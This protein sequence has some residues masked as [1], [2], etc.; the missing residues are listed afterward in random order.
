MKLA[1]QSPQRESF[2][3][4]IYVANSVRLE[5]TEFANVEASLEKV[6]TKSDITGQHV[7]MKPAV[8]ALTG[9]LPVWTDDDPD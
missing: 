6:D 9:K 3:Q 2:K 8:K 1:T 7:I 4:I 5:A